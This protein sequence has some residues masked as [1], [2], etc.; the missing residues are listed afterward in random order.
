MV[1]SWLWG[2]VSLDR[3]PSPSPSVHDSL[4]VSLTQRPLLSSSPLLAIF[5]IAFSSHRMRN[6][7][8]TRR[9]GQGSRGLS[10][11]LCFQQ[12]SSSGTGRNGWEIRSNTPCFS[13]LLLEVTRTAS[14]CLQGFDLSWGESK[15][16]AEAT[17]QVLMN[18]ALIPCEIYRVLFSGCVCVC[19]NSNG[20]RLELALGDLERDW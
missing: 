18:L 14:T 17:A 10:T 9:H 16:F 4:L 15:W 11:H 6:S 2:Y 1:S 12:E 3:Y 19:I 8:W 7:L 13:L 5:W 20:E